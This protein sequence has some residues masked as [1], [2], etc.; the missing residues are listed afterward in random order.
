M[1]KYSLLL[2]L[3]LLAGECV[4]PCKDV[5]CVNGTCVEGTCECDEGWSGPN[6]EID[7]CADV[8]CD[9]GVCASGVCECDDGW[10]GTLCDECSTDCGSHGA[11][12][13]DGE[14]VCTDNYT[15][16]HCETPPSSGGDLCSNTCTWAGDGECDDGG[17]GSDYSVCDCG[18]D[19]QDCGAR[20][21]AECGGGTTT[22]A[23]ISVWFDATDGGFPC[24]TDRID[25]YIDDTY[26]GFLDSYYTSQPECGAGGTVTVEVQS[27]SHTVYAECNDGDTYWGPADF[28]VDAGYCLII[29]IGPNKSFSIEMVKKP[30]DLFKH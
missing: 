10:E 4:N 21:E 24:N 30:N 27:G 3:F 12:N 8:D 29:S 6:C 9:H 5:D 22:D 20:T 18:T 28:S 7:L 16:T 14:C 1:K 26:E 15:G 2:V 19:C 23:A 17:P 11:C 13:N 25:V